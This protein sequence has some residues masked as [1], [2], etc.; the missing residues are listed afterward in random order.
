MKTSKWVVAASISCAFTLA[1]I[2]AEAATYIGPVYF[3]ITT[4]APSSTPYTTDSSGTLHAY[5]V[6][7]YQG[8]S[9]SP[10]LVYNLGDGYEFEVD[11]AFTSSDWGKY[12]YGVPSGLRMDATVATQQWTATG[13][14]S[15]YYAEGNFY[16]ANS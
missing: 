10:F 4:Y 9:G 2:V 6:Q 16:I 1:P 7:Y 8:S 14:P 5:G 15:P 3:D 12:Y 11:G 13:Q